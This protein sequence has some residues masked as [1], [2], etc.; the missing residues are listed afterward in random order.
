MTTLLFLWIS[1]FNLA[2]LAS[3]QSYRWL[4]YYSPLCAKIN[5]VLFPFIIFNLKPH[6]KLIYFTTFVWN[7]Y[8][9]SN[10]MVKSCTCFLANTFFLFLLFCHAIDRAAAEIIS[11]FWIHC[12]SLQSRREPSYIYVRIVLLI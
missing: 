1:L 8:Q 9:L 3:V 5:I 4:P 10:S 7:S 6:L 11:M 2:Y 12:M